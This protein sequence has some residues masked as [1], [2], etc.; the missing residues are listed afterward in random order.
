MNNVFEIANEK[1]NAYVNGAS[2]FLNPKRK[3]YDKSSS[4]FRLTDHKHIDKAYGKS[5]GDYGD[6]VSGNRIYSKRKIITVEKNIEGEDR[7]VVRLPIV[8]PSSQGGFLSWISDLGYYEQSSVVGVETDNP[9]LPVWT[10]FYNFTATKLERKKHNELTAKLYGSNVASIVDYLILLANEGLI[11]C[12]ESEKWIHEMDKVDGSYQLSESKT[13]RVIE[14]IAHLKGLPF[15][16]IK[17][18]SLIGGK[19]Y[20]RS[21]WMSSGLISDSFR[22]IPNYTR[23]EPITASD[24]NGWFIHYPENKDKYGFLYW[25]EEGVR[26]ASG[27]HQILE[28]KIPDYSRRIINKLSKKGVI[29]VGSKAT[30]M[31]IRDYSRK[32]I[33]KELASVEAN[34]SIKTGNEKHPYIDIA[35]SGYVAIESEDFEGCKDNSHLNHR[36]VVR[37]LLLD[38]LKRTKL[39]L[40]DEAEF[41]YSITTLNGESHYT[42][43]IF[44]LIGA[45]LFFD[46]QTDDGEWVNN[47]IC[48]L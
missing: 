37:N 6:T 27:S 24:V 23:K 33:N 25:N 21:Y 29:E 46:R 30:K 47:G 8:L 48:S 1:L 40:S 4:Y 39:S 18:A 45:E 32:I 34:F 10:A 7:E 44:S 11:F 3:Q 5:G 41:S 35:T 12:P 26:E 14:K 17:V 22:L 9:H 31:S 42:S 20:E 13:R 2:S 36:F 16:R 19:T 43:G 28:H 15:K 38:A